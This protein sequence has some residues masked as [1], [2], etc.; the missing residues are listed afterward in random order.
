MSNWVDKRQPIE[1][2]IESL[3]CLD[4]EAAKSVNAVL[5]NIGEVLWEVD[6]ITLTRFGSYEIREATPRMVKPIAGPK[7]GHLIEVRVG[8]A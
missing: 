6:R 3:G 2:V 1:M 8:G 4:T 7:A 5:D